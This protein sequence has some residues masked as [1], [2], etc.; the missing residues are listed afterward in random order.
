MSPWH[1]CGQNRPSSPRQFGDVSYRGQSEPSEHLWRELSR[2]GV[3]RQL[4]EPIQR[5]AAE[6][7]AEAVGSF[8]KECAGGEEKSGLVLARLRLVLLRS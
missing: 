8:R 1:L 6:E 4:D 5:D 2:H 7:V 3:V